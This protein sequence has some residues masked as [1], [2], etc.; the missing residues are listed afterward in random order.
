MN[1]NYKIKE[2]IANKEL[3]GWI[4]QAMQLGK[5]KFLLKY[6]SKLGSISGF[7]V[8]QINVQNNISN[9]KNKTFDIDKSIN[10]QLNKIKKIIYNK[11]NQI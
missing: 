11:I 4:A 3:F 2:I 8:E 9:V 10:L 5:E 6:A 1:Y 7:I